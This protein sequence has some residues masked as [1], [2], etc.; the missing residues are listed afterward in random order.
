MLM[1]LSYNNALGIDVGGKRVGVARVNAIARLPEP[2]GTFSA[3]DF[4]VALAQLIDEHEIDCIVVGLPR[5][6]SGQETEQT[7]AVKVFTED[8]IRPAIGKRPLVFVDET[9]T[10]VAA[11]LRASKEQIA[12]FGID[13]FAA[14]EILDNF[15]RAEG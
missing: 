13:S 10:S 7:K 15:V 12:K 1:A 2:L 5:N 6:M 3:T 8:S 9:L 4:S 11:E 14:A